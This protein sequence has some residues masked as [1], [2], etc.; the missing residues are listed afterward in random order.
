MHKMKK[1]LIGIFAICIAATIVVGET[2]TNFVNDCGVQDGPTL[3]VT[4]NGWD[5][6]GLYETITFDC[7]AVWSDGTKDPHCTLNE[8]PPQWSAD[9]GTIE[10]SNIGETIKWN[11]GHGALSG[12]ITVNYG[13]TE[14]SVQVRATLPDKVSPDY[15]SYVELPKM[16]DAERRAF[17]QMNEKGWENF[18][19]KQ[20]DSAQILSD[21]LE[22]YIHLW[23]TGN[24]PAI[25]PEGLLPNS[26]DN[27]KTCQWKLYRLDEI[28]A[29]EQWYYYPARDEPSLNNFSCLYKNSVAT[30]VTYLK[31]HYIAPFNSTLTI[32]GDFPHAR[33]MSIQVS[34]SYDP[35]FPYVG[36]R[37]QMEVP[38]VDVD[39]EPDSGHVN[40]FRIGADRNAENRHYHVYYDLKAGNMV[41]LNPVLQNPNFRKSDNTRIGG[42]F[43]P[44]GALGTG[45]ILPAAIWIRYYAPDHGTEPFAG[46]S[47]P[48]ATLKL[49]TGEE[50]WLQPDF[51]YA[52]QRQLITMPGTET[53]PHKPYNFIGPSS[54]WFK[55][56]GI[57]QIHAEVESYYKYAWPYGIFP[58][59][60]V[61]KWIRNDLECFN[62]RGNHLPPPGNIGH[63]TTDCPYNSYLART[64][65][66]DEDMVYVITGKMP[67]TPKTRNGESTMENAEARYFSICH[68]GS[69]PDGSYNGVVYGCL[70]DD[71]IIV[72]S[73]NNYIIVYSRGDERPS[74]A[75]AECGVTWQ[76]LGPESR[77]G[78]IMRW[79]S[80]YPDHYMEE[81][82]PNDE[83]IP[84]ATG[85]WSQDTYDKS[86]IGENKA[87]VMGSYH[88]VIH[89]LSREEFEELDCPIELDN[90]PPWKSSQPRG[91]FGI[92][93]FFISKLL[94]SAFPYILGTATTWLCKDC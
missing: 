49:D 15:W 33:F 94:W 92:M 83:N 63:S 52:A 35:E 27:N 16:T 81:Y 50:F 76:E 90:I 69:G 36:N 80:V 25:I 68:S 37:G 13:G 43:T 5:G 74:N 44:S 39:I 59:K 72:D 60:M 7:S 70:M 21:V 1:I 91:T 88:P 65:Q 93:D 30:H 12:T 11:T 55:M 71:E 53:S 41:D 64:L 20:L 34:P 87:G 2:G 77:Q 18:R 32:E 57:W 67:T 56:F 17:F 89:Y 47:L 42:P 66:F 8:S 61:K 75:N 4:P 62:G 51:S 31:S 10:G 28:D 29:E 40:P 82:V 23:Y 38:I 86:L 26:I 78:F 46:V 58:Q 6:Y 84:W 48:K 85:A 24:A 45:V 73:E 22:N 19:Q 3:T 14:K 54:G 9:C 79:M